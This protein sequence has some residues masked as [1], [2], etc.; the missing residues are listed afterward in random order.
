MEQITWGWH[1]IYHIF[2]GVL[3]LQN[4]LPL[5]PWAH[6]KEEAKTTTVAICNM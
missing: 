5:F 1:F 3:F 2:C 6:N 4:V